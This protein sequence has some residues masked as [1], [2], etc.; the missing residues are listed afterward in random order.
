MDRKDRTFK[1]LCKEMNLYELNDFAKQ[2]T[3]AYALS[4]LEYSQKNVAADNHLTL[5]GLRDLM[6]YAIIMALVSR[7]IAIKVFEKAIR[8][9]QRKV[10]NAGSTSVQHY[11]KIIRLREKHLSETYSRI[12]IRDIAISVATSKEPLSY[13]TKIYDLE[14]D[15]VLRWILERAIVENIVSDGEMEAIIAR[16]LKT[17]DNERIRQYFESLRKRR[18][19]LKEEGSQ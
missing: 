7:E 17:K 11:K 10:Y 19:E 16:S 18:N 12:Q 8:N 15:G 14:S 5:K 2:V 9:Q 1:Q 3:E 6:D 4:I 13:F